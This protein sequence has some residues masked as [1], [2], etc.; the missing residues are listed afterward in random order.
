VSNALTLIMSQYNYGKSWHA[1]QKTVE[2]TIR[3]GME[4]NEEA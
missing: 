1:Y 4:W 2:W 3:D